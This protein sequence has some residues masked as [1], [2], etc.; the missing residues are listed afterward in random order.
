[1]LRIES[2]QQSK[3]ESGFSIEIDSSDLLI[4]AYLLLN[5]LCINYNCQLKVIFKPNEEHMWVHLDLS[6]L[7]ITSTTVSA[8][9]S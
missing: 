6:S 3:V 1:M 4:N 2:S 5:Y 9:N 7:K 8:K